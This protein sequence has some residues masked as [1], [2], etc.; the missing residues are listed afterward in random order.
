MA[1]GATYE[2]IATNTL[3]TAT[4]SITFSSIA[5][6]YTDLRLVI[7]GTTSSASG[8]R[9]QFNSDTATNYS[10]TVLY[11]TGAAVASNRGTAADSIYV[12]GWAGTT[13]TTIPTM[14]TVDI[15]SYAGSTYKTLLAINSADQNG[16]GTEE[17]VVG[18]W[19]GT[20]AITSIKIQAG[21]SINLSSGFIATLYGIKAA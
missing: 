2:P 12:M 9:L 4:A 21:T 20:A 1:A 8:I 3:T 13:S 6:T 16:S 17:N 7:V 5:A 18:L 15:F 11:G 14:G 19:R 10:Q